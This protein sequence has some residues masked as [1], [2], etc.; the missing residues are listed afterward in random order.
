[1][2]KKTA[3]TETVRLIYRLAAA[4]EEVQHT[5]SAYWS[6]VSYGLT[7][8][9]VCGAIR[10]WIDAD[11]PI[12]EDATREVDEHMGNAIYII[13]PTVKGQSLYVKVGVY[14]EPETGEYLLIIS[15]HGTF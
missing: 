6:M 3:D 1:M 11:K 2:A 7:K 15:A 13:K 14:Q 8:Y 9:D 10:A 5:A 4:P 12:M